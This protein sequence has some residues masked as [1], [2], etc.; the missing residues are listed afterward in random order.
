MEPLCSG[1]YPTD[2]GADIRSDLAR[3]DDEQQDQDVQNGIVLLPAISGL[4]LRV[5]SPLA[6]CQTDNLLV[7]ST[8][9]SSS[10][11]YTH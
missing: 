9:E 8:D 3:S 4:D 7:R 10:S 6:H 5:H 2:V 11:H 1:I